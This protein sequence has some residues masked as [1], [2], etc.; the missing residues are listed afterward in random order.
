MKHDAIKRSVYTKYDDERSVA[1]SILPRPDRRLRLRKLLFI[2]LYIA[3]VGLWAIALAVLRTYAA[4]VGAFS[5]LTTCMLIFFTWRYTRLEYEITVHAS[6]LGVAVIY[7]GLSRRE[8]LSCR[9]RALSVI[10]PY[11]TADAQT[12]APETAD[13]VYHMVSGAAGRTVYYAIYAGE[14]GQKT[15]LIFDAEEKLRKMLKY[16]GEDRF[17]E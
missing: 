14:D 1:M 2:C 7:G 13:R 9:V 3:F 5:L 6:Q 10:A 17:L 16:Y 15:L 11:E 4:Y 8:L 12:V